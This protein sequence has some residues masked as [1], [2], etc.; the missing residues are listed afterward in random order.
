MGEGPASSP[1]WYRPDALSAFNGHGRVTDFSGVW[2]P[3]QQIE[4]EPYVWLLDTKTVKVP[5]GE[6]TI[7][8]GR[9][10]S[11]K[12]LF[13][14]WLAAGITR[15]GLPGEFYGQPRNVIIC[16]VEDSWARTIKA[17]LELADADLHR[18]GKFTTLQHSTQRKS[19]LTLP[20]H[21]DAWAETVIRLDSP[22]TILDPMLSH[23]GDINPNRAEQV[24]DRLEPL[25]A[26]ADE[27]KVAVP[28]IAHFSKAEG[29]DAM[30]SIGGS[31]AIK[32]LA[33]SV[34]V[35]AR[36]TRDSGIISQPKVMAEISEWSG[37]Y[38]VGSV[39]RPVGDRWQPVPWFTPGPNTLRSV[40][41]LL[42]T[43]SRRKISRAKDFLLARFTM[44]GYDNWLLSKDV[45]D[46]A[47]Q[48][49]IAVRTLDRAREELVPD[50]RKRADG[51]W[52]IRAH[53]EGWRG[54]DGQRAG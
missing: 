1:P 49:G 42:D 51:K 24:R 40:E 4:Q 36:D 30:S 46:E 45:E 37:T 14:I 33:R 29:R 47:K 32:D 23:L 44:A 12:S 38:K 15:G 48:I 31:G 19:T 41:D 3:A 5:L 18:V 13:T 52:E 27:L 20:V 7:V 11:A 34:I 28:C 54:G 6:L 25:V 8:A 2:T 43:G 50:A 16:A 26:M 17:R 53:H 22:L 10:A 9:E 21:L 35:M 39:M